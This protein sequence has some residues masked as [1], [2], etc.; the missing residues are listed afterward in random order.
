MTPASLSRRIV[1]GAALGASLAVALPAAAE[2]STWPTKSVRLIVPYPPGGA[3]DTVARLFAEKLGDALKQSIVVENKPGA[4]TA[5]AAELVAKAPPDGYTLSLVPTGQLTVLPHI[6]KELRFD[7]FTSFTPV[8]QLAYTAVVIAASQKSGI[9]NLADLVTRAKAKPEGVT[10]SSSGSGT[11]IHLAGE[12]FALTS[13]TKLLHV[14]FKGSAPAVSAL[15]SGEIETSF[16]TLTILAPQI[17][18][19]KVKGIAIAAKDR[20]PLLPNVPT[21]AESGFPD[22]EVTS[23]FGL[24]APAGTPKDIVDRINAEITAISAR[25]DVRE[26]LAAQG[27]VPWP[28]TPEQFA[29]RIKADHAKY[30]DVVRNAKIVFE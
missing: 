6:A 1:L 18:A 27:L 22:F 26:A 11:I 16:D 29:A 17:R 14:P 9:N 13:G 15:L 12:Y 25:T 10:Y 28:S 23:W 20:S 5:I 19:D 4:G 7:P 8:S 24:A 3:A 30:G 2:T 21:V